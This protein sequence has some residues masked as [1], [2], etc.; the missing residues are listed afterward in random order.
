M[1]VTLHDEAT[2]FRTH[3]ASVRLPD[4]GPELPSVEPAPE[5]RII[6]PG[7]GGWL[8]SSRAIAARDLARAIGELDGEP[9]RIH[10]VND[11]GDTRLVADADT[12]AVAVGA[13]RRVRVGSA[14]LRTTA[15]EA[16]ERHRALRSLILWECIAHAA[17]DGPTTGAGDVA[18]ELQRALGGYRCFDI[19]AAAVR[20][21]KAELE[22]QR[23]QAAEMAVNIERTTRAAISEALGQTS[24][25]IP[26]AAINWT[27]TNWTLADEARRAY[28][29]V[30]WGV[31]TRPISAAIRP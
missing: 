1:I 17:F 27:D 18:V 11:A 28:N 31:A 23:A 2:P 30:V 9:E 10:L 7:A 26:A 6:V 12:L 14:R 15:I 25:D 13:A 24:G 8:G 3:V 5:W 16:L 21:V 29:M 19:C 20:A 4:D 22:D